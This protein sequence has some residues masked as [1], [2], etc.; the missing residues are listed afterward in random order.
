MANLTGLDGSCEISGIN[1]K[2]NANDYDFA[3][4]R[5]Q[6]K[7]QHIDIGLATSLS[8]GHKNKRRKK[9]KRK[10]KNMTKR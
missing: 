8:F 9:K 3:N 2:N 1:N 7:R 6:E 10:K 5:L 4:H